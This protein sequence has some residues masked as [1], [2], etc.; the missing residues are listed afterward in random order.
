V[1]EGFR[2]TMADRVRSFQRALRRIGE[3][4]DHWFNQDI[5]PG[6]AW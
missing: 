5:P 6:D 4:I 3:F 2:V 1:R